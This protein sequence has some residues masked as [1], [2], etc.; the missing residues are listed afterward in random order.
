MTLTFADGVVVGLALAGML[1]LS[2]ATLLEA[3]RE[4]RARAAFERA[5]QRRL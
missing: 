4:A 5:V 3:R 2:A 1:A